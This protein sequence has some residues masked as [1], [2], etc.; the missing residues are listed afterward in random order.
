[1]VAAQAEMERHGVDYIFTQ[2]SDIEQGLGA[3]FPKATIVCV[4]QLSWLYTWDHT[5]SMS[6]EAS[7]QWRHMRQTLVEYEEDQKARVDAWCGRIEWVAKVEPP[8]T[9]SSYTLGRSNAWS[10]MDP[11]SAA[12]LLNTCVG[13]D[14]HVARSM[15]R[16]M[17][18]G[19][20]M[21]K[22]PPETAAL[23]MHGLWKELMCPAPYSKTLFAVTAHLKNKPS[24]ADE[25]PE[26]AM[27]RTLHPRGE[28]HVD[29]VDAFNFSDLPQVLKVM[30]ALAWQG[31][32][33][34]DPTMR[35]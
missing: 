8:Q 7:A 29:A 22:V 5:K 21:L 3:R 27:S 18:H 11:E 30:Q 2:G 19:M 13:A 34:G 14:G 15:V 23:V 1:M 17:N 16:A 28:V 10:M 32:D 25:F 4:V 20:H 33:R 6:S 24:F 9:W 26:M 31:R 35:D 12:D